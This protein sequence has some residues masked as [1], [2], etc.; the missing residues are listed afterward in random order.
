MRDDVAV[1]S[2]CPHMSPPLLYPPTTRKHT[3]TSPTSTTKQSMSPTIK[4][5]ENDGRLVSGRAHHNAALVQEQALCTCH[6]IVGAATKIF[7]QRLM[8]R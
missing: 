3:T 6:C 7:E 2:P 8:S 5:S 4:L 1:N